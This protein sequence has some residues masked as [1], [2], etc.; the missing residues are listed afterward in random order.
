MVTYEPLWQ[1]MEKRGITSYTL[2]VKHNINPRTI[3]NLK[4]NRG[5]T[6]YTLERLCTILQ[7]TPNDILKFIPDEQK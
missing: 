4:H 2:M 1:T 6:V 7:C 5:I 3:N